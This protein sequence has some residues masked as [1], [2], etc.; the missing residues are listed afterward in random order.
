MAV[1]LEA[2]ARVEREGSVAGRG[3]GRRHR[4]G[5][6]H[7][8]TVGTRAGREGGEG[9]ARS[10]GGHGGGV[11]DTKLEAL[12]AAVFG[13]AAESI[14][15]GEAV[16]AEVALMVARFEMDLGAVRERVVDQTK[17]GLWNTYRVVVSIE[18]CL[19][20]ELLRAG[21]V[22]HHRG[23]RVR[24]LAFGIV[25]LEV[26]FP[27]V[28]ALKQLAAHTTFVSRLFWGGPLALLLDA[29]HAGENRLHVKLGKSAIGAGVK[30]GN[31][32]SRVVFRPL[33][34]LCSVQVFGLGCKSIGAS[35]VGERSI[36]GES[37]LQNM[38]TARLVPLLVAFHF[39]SG[40]I[41]AVGTAL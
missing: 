9:P 1:L 15:T 33:R 5:L 2:G 32:A 18:I 20:L 30:F 3:A 12:G 23:A 8:D 41:G 6:W 26:G 40:S 34:G 4:G 38:F 31:V 10:G 14:A 16:A 28:A 21:I 13:V 37:S 22:A 27:V 24:V 19:A 29:R 7:A 39:Y 11:T 17:L 35:G 36:G 25:R